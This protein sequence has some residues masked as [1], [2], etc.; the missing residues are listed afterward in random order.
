MMFSL[1]KT[2][3]VAATPQYELLGVLLLAAYVLCDSFTSQ[4][5]SRVYR[6][7]PAVDSFQMMYGV[8]V[9]A[10]VL[11]AVA[12]IG[13][14]ELGEVLEFFRYNPSAF[15]FNIVTAVCSSTGQ[16]VIYYIIKRY[17]PV[18]FTIMMTTRQMLSILISNYYFGHDMP[19]QSYMGCLLVFGA[20]L[21]SSYRQLHKPSDREARSGRQPAAGDSRV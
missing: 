16:F 8:N 7:H 4:W 1:S 3:W 12:L 13:S 20:I 11:T 2:S 19:A 18:V 9:S 21:Y 17:G 10:V 14:G 15:Y 5:Q 6:D